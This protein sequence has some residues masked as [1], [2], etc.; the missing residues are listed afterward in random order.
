MVMMDK[1]VGKPAS[2]WVEIRVSECVILRIANPDSKC[3]NK[4]QD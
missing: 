4:I 3:F 2:G 1:Q